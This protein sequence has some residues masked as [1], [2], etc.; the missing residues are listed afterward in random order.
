MTVS[1]GIESAGEE[2]VCLHFSVRDTGIGISDELRNKLFRPFEQGDTSAT[3]HYGGTGLGLAISSRIVEIM[4]GK[5]WVDSTPGA[6]STFHFVVR[7]AK[8]PATQSTDQLADENLREIKLLIV[9]D[10]ATSRRILEQAVSHWQMHPELAASGPEALARL[11]EAARAGTPY[12]LLLLDERMPGMDGFQVIERA[13]AQG[14]LPKAAIMMLT[15]TDQGASAARCHK[16]GISQCMIK[17]IG[18]GELLAAIERALRIAKPVEISEAIVQPISPARQC[19]H[20][21][22]AED[23]P[24]NRKLAAA[25]LEKMG[26]QVTLADNGAE[27]LARW[28]EGQF[29]MI[30]MDVQMPEMDGFE[31]TRQIRERESGRQSHIPIVAMTANAMRGDRGRCV[32]SGM[33]DYIAKPISRRVLT[34]VI[35]RVAPPARPASSSAS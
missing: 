22:V 12:R 27:A 10:H 33:D 17:P 23:N 20:I 30:F 31:A 19:L 15:S 4:E 7:L 16:Q 18:R 25:M 3:R 13:R 24:V 21:L 28:S 14:T 29:D 1:V 35:E 34:E 11:E 9:D 2:D 8:A 26:H 5:L 6:G 32:A